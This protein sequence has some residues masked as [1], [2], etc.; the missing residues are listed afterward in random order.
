MSNK[1]IDQ[2]A[3]KLPLLVEYAEQGDQAALAELKGIEA[4]HI[5]DYAREAYELSRVTERALVAAVVGENLLFREGLEGGLTEFRN[6]LVGDAPTALERLIVE[7]ILCCWIMTNYADLRFVESST[8]RTWTTD[9][10]LQKRQDRA[11]RRFLQACRSLAQ[12]RKLLRPNVQ[13]N[14][15]EKQINM[16]GQADVE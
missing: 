10:Y 9:E 11:Q 15:A 16:M 13:I 3:E 2:S 14:V 6:E 1:T 8:D 12:I 4:A 5:E 7:R